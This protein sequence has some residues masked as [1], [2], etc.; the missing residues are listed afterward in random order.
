M[1]KFVY[2][3]LGARYG[4]NYNTSMARALV[5]EVG[6]T[7]LMSGKIT[8]WSEK[9]AFMSCDLSCEWL[10]QTF[11]GAL[12]AVWRPPIAR[13]GAFLTF[14][15]IHIVSELNLRNFANL[16]LFSNLLTFF[17]KNLVD[18]FFMKIYIFS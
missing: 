8:P 9:S 18:L 5:G 3:F 12:S 10:S 7:V 16:F 17:Q 15:E 6:T 14:F 13:V 2:W 4:F 11:G 1:K